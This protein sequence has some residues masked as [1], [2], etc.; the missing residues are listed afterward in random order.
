MMASRGLPLLLAMTVACALTGNAAVGQAEPD[1]TPSVDATAPATDQAAVIQASDAGDGQV[2]FAGYSRNR[3][4]F[5]IKRAGLTTELERL[6]EAIRDRESTVAALRESR[7]DLY[8]LVNDGEAESLPRL[9]AAAG[10]MDAIAFRLLQPLVVLFADPPPLGNR[11]DSGNDRPSISAATVS[12]YISFLLPVTLLLAFFGAARYYRALYDRHLQHRRLVI[13]C[14]ILLLPLSS[15]AQDGTSAGTEEAADEVPPLAEMLRE[16]D[17]VL[18]L[19]RVQRYIRRLSAPDAMGRRI[20]ISDVDLSATPFTWFDSV[21]GGSGE[22]YATLAALHLA[23]DDESAATEALRPLAIPETRYATRDSDPSRHEAMLSSAA[24]FLINSGEPQL[25][26]DILRLHMPELKSLQTFETLYPELIEHSLTVPAVA[27]A[28]QIVEGTSD[29]QQLLRLVQTFYDRDS[30]ALGHASLV[31]A[32]DEV[33]TPENL[34]TLIEIAI[35]QREETLL[36]RA[37]EEAPQVLAD[38][39]DAIAII[40]LLRDANRQPAAEAFA[41]SVIERTGAQAEVLLDG[42]AVTATRALSE[43]SFAGFERGMLTTAE[44]AALAAI[45]PLSRAERSALLMPAPDSILSSGRIPEPGKLVSPLYLGL[46]YEQQGRPEAAREHFAAA[47]RAQVGDLLATDGIYVPDMMNHLTLLGGLLDPERDSEELAQLDRVLVRLEQNTLDDLRASQAAA[48]SARQTKLAN[49]EEEVAALRADI[50]SMSALLEERQPGPIALAWSTGLLLLRT[51]GLFA[52]CVACATII[53]STALHYARQ[54]RRQRGHAFAWKLLEGLGWVWV[55]SIL[56]APLGL[57]A[58][59]L[60]QFFLLFQEKN[61]LLITM[62]ESP[63]TA[64]DTPAPPRDASLPEKRQTQ[65]D[66]TTDS[67]DTLGRAVLQ[68]LREV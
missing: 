53:G 68:M 2:T 42:D 67:Q 4:D 23:N 45:E 24:L 8:R 44:Q 15:L 37:L 58:V 60:A 19:T 20:R 51:V 62:N 36:R 57:L 41:D 21:V 55:L 52:L 10:D 1:P 17:Q 13:F 14:L 31:R 54:R 49:A 66:E 40:D 50:A 47:S 63:R 38:L 6:D 9:R 30:I 61:E 56:S 64:P 46:L 48:L 65:S 27:L 11:H 3:A 28:Q 32:L 39:T 43:L 7:A 33:D 34:L 29:A 25:A 59:V 35:A 16:A 18:T 5:Q 22:Y 26:H 12:S